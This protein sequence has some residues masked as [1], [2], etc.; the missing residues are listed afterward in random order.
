[1]KMMHVDL[2]TL[3]PPEAMV[4]AGAALL[5]GAVMLLVLLWDRR[6]RRRAKPRAAATWTSGLAKTRG[7]LT[8]RLVGAWGG[9]GAGDAW[10]SEVEE[11]LLSADV[12]VAATRDLLEGFRVRA[13]GVEDAAGLR[14]AMKSAVRELWANETQ[15]ANLDWDQRPRVILVVGV[16]GVGKTTTIGKLAHYYVQRGKKVL[17]VAGDTFRAAATEQLTLWAE[18]VGVDLVKHQHGADPSAVGFDGVKAAQARGV[19]V[20]I[21]DTA[22]RLHVKAN[23]MEE[24]KKIVRTVGRQAAGAPH[25][26]LLVIDATTGQNA[27]VQSRVFYEAVDVTGFVLA[28]LDGTARGGITLAIRKELGLPIQ[29][30]GLWEQAE[31]LAA[32]DAEEFVD[33]LFAE[34]EDAKST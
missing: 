16:N 27:L 9:P 31:D 10:L 4:A 13:S 3:T 11:I 12:G 17:L 34:G 22:G 33:A 6:R 26:I 32:F 20:V 14:E 24:L 18:R 28:K 19:D 23:L 15:V 25:E 8:E 5:I 1:M 30:V 7:G 29:W 2:L 21:V